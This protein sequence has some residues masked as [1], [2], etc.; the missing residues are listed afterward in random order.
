MSPDS[1]PSENMVEFVG[2]VTV[3]VLLGGDE[4]PA[5]SLAIT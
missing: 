4:F 1:K 3:A 2:V 5:A